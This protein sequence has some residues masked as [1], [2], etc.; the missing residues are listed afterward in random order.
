[1]LHWGDVEGAY[2]ERVLPS[3]IRGVSVRKGLKG[4]VFYSCYG[5]DERAISKAQNEQQQG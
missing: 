3:V 4:R 5:D 2:D 1:M